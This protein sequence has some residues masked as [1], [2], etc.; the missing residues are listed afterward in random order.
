[1]ARGVIF[2]FVV[3]Y[4]NKK[5]HWRGKY[6]LKKKKCMRSSNCAA[7]SRCDPPKPPPCC[8]GAASLLSG[9]YQTHMSTD[10]CVALAI[11]SA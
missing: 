7:G 1:M 3:Q 11:D 6:C 9:T 10:V 5:I 4:E 2:R 8:N